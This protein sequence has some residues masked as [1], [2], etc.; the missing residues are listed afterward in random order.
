MGGQH[1][2]G[3]GDSAVL[4]PPSLLRHNGSATSLPASEATVRAPSQSAKRRSEAAFCGPSPSMHLPPCDGLGGDF[5]DDDDGTDVMPET[6][7]VPT[8]SSSGGGSGGGSAIDFQR[9]I[10]HRHRSLG[11]HRSLISHCSS[12]GVP[13]R[14]RQLP[15]G[16]VGGDHS[17]QRGQ[18]EEDDSLSLRN[19]IRQREVLR[20][21]DR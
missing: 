2:E 21:P 14:F 15:D 18:S 8:S 6:V 7:V 16:G 4:Q 9:S 10:L 3:G 1:L 13:F 19:F 5:D 11:S 17:L 12:D 20:R